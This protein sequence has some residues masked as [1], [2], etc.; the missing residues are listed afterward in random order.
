MRIGIMSFAHLHAASYIQ[1]IRAMPDVEFIGFADDNAERA[2]QVAAQ[3]NAPL[4]DSY[5]ALLAEKPDAVAICSENVNHRYMTEMAAEAGAHVLCEKPLATSIEDAQ[6]MVDACEKAGV[7]LMT[8]F[9]MRFNAPVMAAYEGRSALGR[10]YGCATTN[11]GQ[12]PYKA[13]WWFVDKKL[14]GGGAMTDHTVHVADLLRWFL[15]SE[16]TEVYA[17][18]NA[19][20]Y[21]DVDTDVETGGLVMLTFE[22]GVFATIDCSWSKPQYYPTWGGVTL[23]IVGE[24]GFAKI[25]AF[26]QT[27]TVYSHKNQRPVLAPWGSNADAGMVREFIAS[28][29]EGRPPRVTGYD[30]LK[31]VEI[32][33]AAYQSAE[34]GQPVKLG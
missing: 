25:D 9:P 26:D 31:A 13:R 2:K 22:N 12:M 6:A 32:V 23:E 15:D 28:I 20:L 7:N 17:Q 27:I 19:I 5:E 3:F 18:S 34:T 10:I 24:S 30:G 33:Q 21:K 16:V 14:S 11:Q 1:Q 8:A 4:F 29:R